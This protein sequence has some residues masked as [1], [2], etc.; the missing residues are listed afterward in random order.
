MQRE[1]ETSGLCT[2]SFLGLAFKDECVEGQ[3]N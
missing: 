1:D 3:G 2:W